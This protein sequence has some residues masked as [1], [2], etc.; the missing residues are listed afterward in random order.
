MMKLEILSPIDVLY[1]GEVTGVTLPSSEGQIKVLSGHTPYVGALET[2][3]I[4]IEGGTNAK[5]WFLLDGFV[6]VT[7]DRC[8]VTS[9]SLED[10]ASFDVASLGH[11]FEKNEDRIRF[12]QDA[13]D[14]DSKKKQEDKTLLRQRKDEI[15]QL[16]FDNKIIDT[17]IIFA[18]QYL[19]VNKKK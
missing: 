6:D 1:T 18:K 11:K 12:L 16:M 2:G 15:N 10:V 3:I 14:Q 19:A 9:D 4:V 7:S 5:Q 17:K 13:I 8:V